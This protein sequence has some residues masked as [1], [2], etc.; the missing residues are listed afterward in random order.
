MIALWSDI[1]AAQMSPEE[2]RDLST[3]AGRE[4]SVEQAEAYRRRKTAAFSVEERLNAE[5]QAPL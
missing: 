3:E 5:A 2:L 1:P 4:L